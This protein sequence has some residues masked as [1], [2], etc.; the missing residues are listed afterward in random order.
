MCE[1]GGV[2]WYKVLV[3]LTASTRVKYLSFCAVPGLVQRECLSF[4]LPLCS[5]VCQS[6]R[7]LVWFS[8]N[9]SVSASLSVCVDHLVGCLV[10]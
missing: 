10:G 6:V 4:C 2:M 3:A 1:G 5:S 9:A 7:K 8:A